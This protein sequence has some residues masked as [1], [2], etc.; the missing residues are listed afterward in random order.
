VCVPAKQ[1]QVLVRRA[2]DDVEDVARQGDAAEHRV[3]RDVREHAQ[4]DHL[5]H[6][7]LEREHEQRGARDARRGIPRP[8]GDQAEQ[9]VEAYANAHARD[10]ERGVE[11]ARER[12][13]P[14]GELYRPRRW[15]VALGAHF[16]G[17]R[18]WLPTSVTRIVIG[19]GHAGR[20]SESASREGHRGQ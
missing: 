10:H 1:R 16:E 11:Q 3:D 8:R 20:R 15:S 13:R 12:L 5:R 7:H 6:A 4:K 18:H 14:G 17:G 19:G 2:E 9:G